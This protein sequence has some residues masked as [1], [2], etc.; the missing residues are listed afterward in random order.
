MKS[1]N[2]L[3]RASRIIS[4]LHQTE[5]N[6]SKL[7]VIHSRLCGTMAGL[8]TTSSKATVFVLVILTLLQLLNTSGTLVDQR[9]NFSLCNCS[10]PKLISYFLRCD[11]Q[12]FTVDAALP[13]FTKIGTDLDGKA[14]NDE[15]SF[16]TCI[17][18]DCDFCGAE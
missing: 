18:A 9:Y 6:Y 4:F 12:I 11:I 7:L 8:T 14:A 17:S 10:S 1:F 5:P 16:S 13:A 15:Y 3:S 2:A